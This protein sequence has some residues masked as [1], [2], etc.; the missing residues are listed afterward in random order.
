[1]T[2]IEAFL[3]N[4]ILQES[5]KYGFPFVERIFVKLM[6]DMLENVVSIGN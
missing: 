6:L 2:K 3:Q 4:T 5:L 1:M